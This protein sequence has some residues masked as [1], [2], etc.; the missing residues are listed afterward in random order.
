MVEGSLL[1]IEGC[2]LRVE[3]LV[4]NMDGCVQASGFRIRDSGSESG[5]EG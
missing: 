4:V 5:V 3:G 1:G 2:G